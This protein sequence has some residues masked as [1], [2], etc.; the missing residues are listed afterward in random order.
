VQAIERLAHRLRGA[1][2]N[3]G[4]E[5]MARTAGALED[6]CQAGDPGPLEEDCASLESGLQVMQRLVRSLA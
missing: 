4:H 5:S 6:R 1:S 3:L 2:L